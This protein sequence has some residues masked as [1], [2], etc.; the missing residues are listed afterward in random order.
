MLK[1][2]LPQLTSLWQKG[3]LRFGYL[4][5]LATAL[6]LSNWSQSYAY[7]VS[8]ESED[9]IASEEGL[10]VAT[11]LLTRIGTSGTLPVNVQITPG[12]SAVLTTDYTLEW[13]NS[14]LG[15]FVHLGTNP[16]TG[17]GAAATTGIIKFQDGEQS[18]R[19]KLTPIHDTLVEQREYVF[20]EILYSPNY[21]SADSP[22]RRL[23]IADNDHKARIR[24]MQSV[25]D[26]D[27]V[28]RGD[29][30][31]VFSRRRG[32]MRVEFDNFPI[33]GTYLDGTFSRNIAIQFINADP[34]KPTIPLAKLDTDYVVKYKTS[35]HSNPTTTTNNRSQLGRIQNIDTG[36]YTTTGLNF[37]LMAALAGDVFIPLQKQ[38]TDDDLSSNTIPPGSLI[39]FESDPNETIY[40]VLN[41]GP[42]ALTLDV[43]GGYTALDRPVPSGTSVKVV[44]AGLDGTADS[45]DSVTVERK[46]PKGSTTLLLGEGWV[47]LYEGDVIKL[48]GDDLTYVLR[49]DPIMTTDVLTRKSAR[50]NIFAYEGG[51]GGGIAV[52]QSTAA[53]VTTL[54]TPSASNWKSEENGAQLEL[55][56]PNNSTRL[57]ISIEPTSNDGAEAVEFVRMKIIADED[58][59]VLSPQDASITVADRD[60]TAG[61]KVESSAGLPNIEGSFRFTL[62]QAYSVPVKVPFQLKN[63]DGTP[64][65]SL[66]GEGTTFET[67]PR[68]VTFVPGQTTLYLPVRPIIGGTPR[69][70]VLSLTGTEDYKLGGSTSSNLNPS[71]TMHIND[72]VGTV[73]I[74]ATVSSATESN[75]S[76]VD[77]I[78]TVTVT[79]NTGQVGEVSLRL[80]VS[81]TAINGAR[82]EFY[83]PLLPTQTY[84]VSSGQLTQIRILANTNSVQIGARPLDNQVAD[85]GQSVQLA[86]NNQGTNYAI[87]SSNSATVTIADNEPVVSVAT[88][89][90]ASRPSTPGIF[91]FTYPG[92]PAGQSLSHLV[93]VKFTL[94]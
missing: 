4:S 65:T 20:L 90:N 61:V 78:F 3:I 51:H 34:D 86:L 57:E 63:L 40:R 11:T 23:T 10:K 45:P 55:L 33:A 2:I 35:G 13:Y 27:T 68:V 73:T 26:E 76:P 47:D 38:E 66:T 37:R 18:I 6:L 92:V 30:D 58:Y 69:S 32:I 83:N 43:T 49:S 52:E 56:V 9:S 36:L 24:V 71:A 12:S 29:P 89:S 79:R 94:A 7:D 84:S 72:V 87:G 91:R 1:E 44:R 59:V 62:S 82:Y 21:N 64:M 85:G 15:G 70:M 16:D 75:I 50:V 25:A 81:G 67:L 19:V 46:Y 74:A 8:F 93:V 48:A 39:Y 60:V 31:D 77:G 41:A 17:V 88:I 53:D 22:T 28:L 14:A 42:T 80:D 54:I 5:F